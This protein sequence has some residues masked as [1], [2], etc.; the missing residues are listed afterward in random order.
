MGSGR[1]SQQ[2]T[3]QNLLPVN[4][5]NNVDVLMRQALD[6]YNSGGREYYQGDTVADYNPLQSGGQDAMLG[7]ASGAGGD[8]IN[9]AMAGN[10]FFMDPN[11]I[12]NLD[13]IPG[14][15]DAQGA[16]TDL[17]T[18]NL[19]ENILPSVRGGGT[20]SG[21]Y[22]GS[23]TGI[24][25]ALSV[26]RSSEGL[27]NAL[28]GMDLAA[29]GQGL[30]SFNQA[31]NRAPGLFQLGAQPATIMA[32][33][34]DAQQGQ[35]QREIDANVARHM[36]EQNE[37]GVLLAMLQQL[38]GS[39]GQYGGTQESTTTM[40]PASNPLGQALGL[41]LMGMSAFGGG[42]MPVGGAGKGGATGSL[43]GGMN[44]PFQGTSTGTNPFA[45][46]FPGM[47]G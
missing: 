4:Q 26:G 20:S 10:S 11:N 45:N 27:S 39:A 5:Q 18:R 7:Y 30:N 16:T 44:T 2:Q 8:F 12:F 32:N 3:T 34:G 36:F 37:P 47:T 24:G 19:T 38:T 42:G 6:Y 40:N 28:A 13:N 21:Q 43:G 46:M 35:E 23:A 29:Y 41:G 9:Q 33:I 22:G 15:R 25:E 14:Y 1:S 17:F 31:Q